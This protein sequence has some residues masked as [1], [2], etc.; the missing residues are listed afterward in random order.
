M[1]FDSCAGKLPRSASSHFYYIQL[2][3][4]I[5]VTELDA[6]F[7][8]LGPLS[9]QFLTLRLPPQANTIFFGDP[10]MSPEL[11]HIIWFFETPDTLTPPNITWEPI[12]KKSMKTQQM[13][14]PA[15][16]T[17][18]RQS[19]ISWPPPKK[20]LMFFCGPLSGSL[21]VVLYSEENYPQYCHQFSTFS[22]RLLER[23]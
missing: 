14:H 22:G 11:S 23:S 15:W 10:Q 7:I 9:F 1:R 2:P 5:T 8:S 19:T 16:Q 18:P 13:S 21:C 6:G 4:I 3:I 17:P 12:H 20:C